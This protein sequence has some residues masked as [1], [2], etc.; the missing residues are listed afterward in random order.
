MMQSTLFWRRL[1]KRLLRRHGNVKR[2][3]HA[4]HEHGAV[5]GIADIGT[6]T[7]PAAKIVG[8]VGRW[9]NLRSDFFYRQGAAMTER[10]RRIGKAMEQG[11]P[12]PPLELYKL[13][14]QPTSDHQSPAVSEYYVVDGHHR[15]AMA[16]QLGQDF[17]D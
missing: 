3:D 8:S 6:R 9:R 2:F 15:V 17:L 1:L 12:L 7:V 16:K 5:S 14:G 4:V 11:K 13:K 10:F